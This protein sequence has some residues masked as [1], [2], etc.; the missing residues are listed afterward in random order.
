MIKR[1]ACCD[2]SAKSTARAVSARCRSIF[3]GKNGSR[4]AVKRDS[5]MCANFEILNH[6]PFA[7]LALRFVVPTWAARVHIAAR[8]RSA[9]QS[10]RARGGPCRVLAEPSH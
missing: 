9:A 5:E 10:G 8:M 1:A 4:K 2:K 3:F 6:A 7:R